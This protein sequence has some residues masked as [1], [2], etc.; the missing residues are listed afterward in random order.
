[1]GMAKIEEKMKQITLFGE[2][3]VKDELDGYSPERKAI[4]LAH[5][6]EA[7]DHNKRC[8]EHEEREK[9]KGLIWPCP[10][11]REIPLGVERANHLHNCPE[12]KKILLEFDKRYGDGK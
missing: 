12:C 4:I 11:G 8:D 1:M 2:E 7:S 3:V 5:L 6:K 10:V 9:K